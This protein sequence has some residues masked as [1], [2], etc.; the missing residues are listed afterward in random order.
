[1]NFIQTLKENFSIFDKTYT[2]E[3]IINTLIDLGLNKKQIIIE[4][5]N[6]SIVISNYYRGRNAHIELIRANNFDDKVV[7]TAIHEIVKLISLCDINE[8]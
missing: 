6:C 8:H 1:M 4:D 3:E 5:N 2:I 7:I